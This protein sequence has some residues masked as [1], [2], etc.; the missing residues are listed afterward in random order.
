MALCLVLWVA[1]LLPAG[2]QGCE[3]RAV[4]AGGELQLLPKEPPQAWVKLEWKVTLDSG[5]QLVI[6]RVSKDKDPDYRNRF[7]GRAT[8]H[9]ETLSLRISPVTQADSGNYSADFEIASGLTHSQC[10]HVSVWEPIGQPRLEVRMLQQ[11][12]GWCNFSLLCSVPGAAN[13]SY[14][15]SRDEEP[16]GHENVLQVHGGTEPRTYICNASNPV[17]S[18]TASIDTMKACFPPGTGSSIPL[19]AVAVPLVLAVSLVA[20]VAWW[21]WRKRRK[22]GSAAPPGPVEPSMTVYEEVGKV[23]A[24]QDLNRNREA[25]VVGN[26]IYAVVSTKAQGSRHFQEPQSCTIYSTIQPTKKQ[27]PTPLT[28]GPFS[29]PQ[30]PSVRRKKL[31]PALVCTAYTEP[32]VPLKHLSL[33]PRTLSLS[34]VDNHHS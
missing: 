21:C 13:V 7:S 22:D 33:P 25:N 16:L 1:A 6:V 20:F 5:T 23:Q 3:D 11:E 12:Q 17:S 15:W 10:F 28:A 4:P 18:S 9:P 26:T 32:T 14:S 2:A 24:G 31:D 29:A 34:P 27:P 19:W 8:F 30:S